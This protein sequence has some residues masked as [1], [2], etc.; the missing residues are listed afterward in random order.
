MSIHHGN[1]GPFCTHCG[2]HG[3]Q[4]EEGQPCFVK[5]CE[6]VFRKIT[7]READRKQIGYDFRRLRHSLIDRYDRLKKQIREREQ[8]EMDALLKAQTIAEREF[9]EANRSTD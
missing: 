7:Q 5:G 8:S 9:D 1:R 2:C 6:G 3:A 4:S